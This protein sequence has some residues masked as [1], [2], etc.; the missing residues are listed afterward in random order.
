MISLGNIVLS[1]DLMLMGIDNQKSVKVRQTRTITGESFITVAKNIGGRTLALV[2]EFDF[3]L[4]IVNQINTLGASGGKVTLI[5]PRGI[6]TVIITGVVFTPATKNPE[7][8][9][10]E[11]YSGEITMI[12]V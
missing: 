11:W 4:D 1:D 2:G 12:E 6:F 8:E 10:A 3:T 7:P 5:H 9:L